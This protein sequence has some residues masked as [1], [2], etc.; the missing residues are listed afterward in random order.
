MSKSNYLEDAILDH[1]LKNTA[2]TQPT[3]LF[4]ALASADPTDAGTGASMNELTSAG[5]YA[6]QSIAFAV[7]SGGAAANSAPVAY[8]A[9]GAAFSAVATHFAVL[10]NA[11]I[12]AGNMLYFAALTASRT[13]NDG[14][15]GTFATGELDLTED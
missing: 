10:D 2:F 11:T 9:T 3:V 13:F 5:G 1:V 7:A 8:T 14:D 12:G 6:R 4:V 15:T